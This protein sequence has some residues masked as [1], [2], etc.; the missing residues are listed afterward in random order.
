VSPADLPALEA[1]AAQRPGD[2]AAALRLARAYYAAGRFVDAR[3]AAQRAVALAPRNAEARA[4]LG[5]A[6]EELAQFDSARAIYTR[7]LEERP[8]RDVQ[9]L[10]RGRLALLT[11]RELQYAARQAIARESLL[12]STAPDPNTVAVMPFRYVGRDSSLRPL[13]RGLAALVVTDLSRVRRLR[14]VERERLQV[15]LDELKIAEDGRGDPA[16]SARSGRLV[17]AGQMVQGQFQEVPTQQLRIDATVVRAADAEVAASGSGADRLQALFD[18]EKAVVFQLLDRMGITL[19]PQERQQISERPT[20]DLQAFLL[21]SRGLEAQDRG[22]FGAASQAFQAAARQDPSFQQ[23]AQQA[24]VAQDAAATTSAPPVDVATSL[25]GGPTASAP[26]APAP[27]TLGGALAN[28]TPSGADKIGAVP[29]PQAGGTVSIGVDAPKSELPP[30]APN[31]LCE[32]AAACGPPSAALI[33]T[34]I[35]IIRRP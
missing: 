27:G 34:L 21:Y 8:G 7:L 30:P 31:K 26:A 5:L 1:Q 33:G 2:G 25:G 18:V 14:L 15:L 3:Q 35:I 13:E 29:E 4:Y 19:T 17:G 22:D 11:R 9:R 20:R 12:T 6:H 24:A 28:V 10:L 32:S 16:T 23:A